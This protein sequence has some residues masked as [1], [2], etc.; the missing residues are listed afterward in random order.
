[1]KIWKHVLSIFVLGGM[2]IIV[3][4][5]NMMMCA[6]TFGPH[7]SNL[8]CNMMLLFGYFPFPLQLFKHHV[9]D[10]AMLL[11]F[12]INNIFVVSVVYLIILWGYRYFKKNQVTS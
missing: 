6:F 1:M 3:S 2:M 8:N 10:G 9:S 4:V 12:L 11:L 5:A 7:E